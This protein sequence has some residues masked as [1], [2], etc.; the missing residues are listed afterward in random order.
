MS[1][2]SRGPIRKERDADTP[3]AE[4]ISAAESADPTLLGRGR[5]ARQRHGQLALVVMPIFELAGVIIDVRLHV[6]VTMTAQVEQDRAARALFLAAQRLVDRPL[7]G[8]VG[9]G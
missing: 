2:A 7:D 4:R 9:L 6:E 3:V 1:R 8:V 5:E